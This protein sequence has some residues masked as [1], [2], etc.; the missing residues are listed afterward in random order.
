MSKKITAIDLHM[1]ST[2]SDGSYTPSELVDGAI[3]QNLSAFAL[4]DHD[5]T[6]GI[7][8]A[9]NYA[10]NKP[11]RVI[12]GI[13]LSTSYGSIDI[14]IVGI[15][16][17]RTS[18]VLQKH[19]TDIISA[20]TDRNITMCKK[21]EEHEIY[22]TLEDLERENPDSVLT[23]AHIAKY[24]FEHGHTK[25]VREAF[26]RYV[27]DHASCYVPRQHISAAEGVR[28]IRDAGGIP[29]LAHP[30]LYPFSNSNLEILVKEL[31]EAG[32]VG[33]ETTYST[34]SM[35]DTAKIKALAKKY[36]LLESGG[37]DF[38]GK[39]KPTIQIGSG[40]GDLF[41]PSTFLESFEAYLS[42][43]K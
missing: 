24:L 16:I 6:V 9:I 7:D 2:K 4:T 43:T 30:I 33:I 41:V 37:S 10:N 25:S 5:T 39:L 14:H 40:R 29:I 21:F 35:G 8:E 11:I 36:N 12:P 3:K 27:G 23:R 1:H 26:D 22:F 42:E 20:R 32:L 38:H 13:E 18:K 31:S 34:Y 19:L 17:D 28:I 15:F